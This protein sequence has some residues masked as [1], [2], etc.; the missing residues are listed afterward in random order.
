M[1]CFWCFADH[2]GMKPPKELISDKDEP[3][4]KSLAE[5]ARRILEEYVADL[6]EILKKLRRR[7]N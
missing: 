1:I 3:P 2:H 4:P 6:R 7:L 5:E